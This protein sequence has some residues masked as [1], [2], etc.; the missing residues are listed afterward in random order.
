MTEERITEGLCSLYERF[1][2]NRFKMSKFEQ[3]EL[4]LTNK[5]F[6]TS[7]R[8]VTFPDAHGKLLALK[9]DV[10]LSIVKSAV[11]K[12]S[13]CEKVYYDESVYRTA[14]GSDEL[15]E[16]TQIGVE[17]ISHLDDYTVFEVIA[18]AHKSLALISDDYILAISHMGFITAAVSGIEDASVQRAV[19][20]CISKKNAHTLRDILSNEGV[21]EKTSEC[22][23]TLTGMFGKADECI[24]MLKQISVNDDT[25]AAILKMEK[26]T[27]LL[28]AAGLYD[29]TVID[30]SIVNNMNYYNGITFQGFVD[31]VAQSVLS[32]GEYGK[33]MNKFSSDLDAIGFAVYLDTIQRITTAKSYDADVFVLY[34]PDADAEKLYKSILTLIEQGCSVRTGTATV[35]NVKCKRTMRFNGEE[36]VN[37]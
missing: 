29:K 37:E 36:L 27:S 19:L 22:L 12:H 3:Y 20:E 6:L 35:G 30:F 33:L 26:I 2:Y 7:E 10:T 9:P 34:S 17:C 16:L 18:L 25:D 11:D 4:Y 21:D 15:K 31:R 28:K 8:I 23:M 13:T 14:K 1:G 24:G 5:D 32:G